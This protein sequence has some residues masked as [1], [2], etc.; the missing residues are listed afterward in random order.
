MRYHMFCSRNSRLSTGY[1]I[2][3]IITMAMLSFAM[4]GCENNKKDGVNAH[5]SYIK[6]KTAY[7]KKKYSTSIQLFDEFITRYPYSSHLAEAKLYSADAYFQTKEYL[8][9]AASFRRFSILHPRHPKRDFA[10]YMIGLSY[11]HHSPGSADRELT[12]VKKALAAWQDLKKAYPN[13]PYLTEVMAL[14]N[15]GNAR[16]VEGELKVAQFYCRT[17]KWL[18]CLHLV[19]QFIV[20][21]QSRHPELTQKAAKTGLVAVKKLSKPFHQKKLDLKGH[22][23]TR[24]MSREEFDIFLIKY[25]RKWEALASTD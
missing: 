19:D 13:S 11:W 12:G 17:K 14:D 21:H 10:L 2:V 20:G 7:D 8:A 1:F 24:S 16:M 25:R 18:N 22:L 6:A 3:F 4:L 5:E 23:I 15:Q 9:A